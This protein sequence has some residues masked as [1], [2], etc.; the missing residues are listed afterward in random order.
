MSRALETG[1][2]TTVAASLHPLDVGGYVVDTPGL[3]KLQFWEVSERELDICFPEF[4]PYLGACRF[5][6]CRHTQEPG[7]AVLEA[8]ESGAISEARHGSY[9]RILEERAADRPY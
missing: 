2:H 4:R 5:P 9:V 3:G 7:C 6:D 1:K 8:V